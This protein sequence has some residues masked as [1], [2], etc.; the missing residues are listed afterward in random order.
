MRCLP[1]SLRL[2]SDEAALMG[3]F[4]L[5]ALVLAIGQWRNRLVGSLM[6]DLWPAH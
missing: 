1:L 2:H 4:R 5:H 3:M 6:V